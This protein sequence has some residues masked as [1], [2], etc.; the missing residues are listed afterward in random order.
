M[1]QQK[2]DKGMV[3]SRDALI[4]TCREATKA[5]KRLTPNERAVLSF[6]GPDGGD[7]DWRAW[8]FKGIGRETGLERNLVRRACRSLTRKGYAAFEKGLW[9]EDGGP[10]GSGYRATDAGKHLYWLALTDEQPS[11]HLTALI[12]A[13]GE[14]AG[15]ALGGY[16]AKRSAPPNQTGEA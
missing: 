12:A 7:V 10:R 16:E 9:S 14:A 5:A 13:L 1:E 2:S 15:E 11:P 6:I 3:H 8:N 4:P